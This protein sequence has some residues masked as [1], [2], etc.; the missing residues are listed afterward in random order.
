[1]SSSRVRILDPNEKPSPVF[2]PI[3]IIGAG[4]GGIGA[5]CRL[6]HLGYD[7]FR[8]FE[9]ESGLGGTWW[10]N[11][12]PGVSKTIYSSG[13]DFLD[14]LGTAVER[15]GITSNIRLNSEVTM[16]E[17]IQ[18][19]IVIS[20]VGILSEPNKPIADLGASNGQVIHSARWPADTDLTG[21]DVV[22]VGSGC[23]AA[24]IVPALLQTPV[25]SLTQIMRT[26]PWV[27]PR[28]EEPGGKEAYAKWAP[29]IYGT[30][31]L[32]GFFVPA[33]SSLAHMTAL[34]PPKYHRILTPQYPVGCKRRIFDSDWL[35]CMHDSRFTLASGSLTSVSDHEVNV[36][37]PDASCKELTDRILKADTLILATG[38]DTHEFKH[39]L[40]VV[41]RDGISLQDQWATRGGP[42]AYMCTAVDGFPNFFMVRGPNTLTGHTSAIMTMENT[43]EYILRLIKPVLT[44]HVSIVEPKPEAVQAW[45]RAIQANTQATVFR[46]CTSWYKTGGRNVAV[47][48]RSQVD[49]HLRCRFPRLSNWN[50]TMTVR[51]M[52]RQRRHWAI[53]YLAIATVCFGVLYAVL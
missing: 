12:Y 48:P 36:R 23:S 33:A 40:P 6:K 11:R 28:L 13:S 4:A 39:Y 7:K 14:Y 29:Q 15:A 20:A 52:N 22:V 45:D 31:P 44:G 27:V 32:L 37:G 30:V 38:F 8:V 47:Y 17:V 42:H 1:M 25:K 50:R 26:P 19:K 21:Q 46:V 18:A 24:Q 43:I 16:E 3:A 41:G 34:A 9:R 2:Y 10:T 35:K 49:Y 51:G 5:A 53:G